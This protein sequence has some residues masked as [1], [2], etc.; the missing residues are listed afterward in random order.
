MKKRTKTLILCISIFIVAAASGFGLWY[1]LRDKAPVG[2]GNVLGVAWYHE[3]GTEF[4][5]TT[6][7]ELFELAELSEHYD[8]KDQ[9][10]KLGADIVVNEGNAAD[11]EKIMPQRRWEPITGFAGTF[12][13]QGHTISGLYGLGHFYGV[14]GTQSVFYTT[15]MFADTKQDCVIKNFKLL[16]SYFSSDLNEGVGSISSYGGG[17]FDSIYTDAIIVS[18]KSNNGGIVGLL[19]KKATITNCWFDGE[20]RVEGNVGRFTGGIVGRVMASNGQYKIE[21]CLNTADISSTVTNRG[22][23]TGGIAGNVQAQARITIEDSLTVGDISVD[24]SSAVG[25]FIGNIESSAAVIVENTYVKS[26]AFTH[27]I[28]NANGTMT[29][30]PVAHNEATLTGYDAYKWSELDFENYWAVVEDGTP[31]LQDFADQVPSLEGI[32]KGYDT[33]WYKP[34]EGEYLI[35]TAE[36]LYGFAILSYS[37]DFAGQAIYLGNDIV[38][39]E[40]DAKDWAENAPETR[41]IP[42]S[43]YGYPFDGMFD[44]QG[45]VISGVYLNTCGDFGL[46]GETGSSSIVT[47]LKLENSYLE[48]FGSTIGSV[49]GRAAGTMQNV[50]SNAIVLGRAGNVGGL[51]G[52]VVKKKGVQMADCWFD[53]TVTNL[54]NK[55]DTK[56]IGGLIGAVRSNCAVTNCLNTGTVDASVFNFNQSK[57]E[58][59]TVVPIVGG[60]IGYVEKEI[61]LTIQ[62][63]LNAGQVLYNEAATAAY[64]SAIGYIDGD[65][66]AYNLYA[67]E[68]SCTNHPLKQS[69]TGQVC[70]IK[71]ADLTGYKAYQWTL[72]DFENHWAINKSGTPILKVFAT[73]VPSLAGV[74]KEVDISWYATDKKTFTLDSREDLF[75]FRLMSYNTDFAEKTVKLGKNITVNTGDAAQWAK[76]APKY[77]WTPI[78]TQKYSFKG[79]FD[80]GMHSINGLYVKT[81]T[82]F[83]G[84]FGVLT[85]GTEVKNLKI[86][87]SY[88][89]SSADFL[90]SIVGAGNADLSNIY[91]NAILVSSANGAAG[92]VGRST[93]DIKI[94]NCW[95]DGSA[96]ITG[97]GMPNRRAGGIVA[98]IYSGKTTLSHCLN[99]GSVSA[100]NYTGTNSE[101]SKAVV[102]LIG[103][104]VGQVSRDAEV[105]MDDSLNT[106]LV[107]CNSAATTGYSAVIGYSDGKVTLTDTFATKESCEYQA[108]GKITGTV[109]TYEEADISG[110]GGYQWMNLNFDKYWAVVVNPTASTPILQSFASNVPSLAGIEKLIDTS[111]YDEQK[112]EYVLYDKSDLNGLAYLS[113]SINFE[114]KTIK[115]GADIVVN[116]DMKNPTYKWDSIGS[117]NV[118]FAGTFDGCMHT[119]SGLYVNTDVE[120][121]GLFARTDKTATVKNLILKDSYF[122]SNAMNIGSIAGI[123]HGTFDTIKSEATVVGHNARVGGLIGIN[124]AKGTSLTNCWFAGTVTNKGNGNGLRGTG[125]LV[126]VSYTGSDLTIMNCLNTGTVDASAYEYNQKTEANPQVVVLAGGL[127]GWVRTDVVLTLGDSLNTGEVKVSSKSED[128][129][130]GY[131]GYGS[132]VGYVDG[133]VKN[134]GNFY[135]TAESSP[136]QMNN[137][138][139]GLVVVKKN[140]IIGLGGYQWDRLNLDFKNIWTLVKQ[141][142]PILQSFADKVIDIAKVAKLIDTSWYDGKAGSTYKLYDMADLYG[143]AEL[144]RKHDFAGMTVKL[145]KDI[146][147]NEGKAANWATVAPEYVWTPIGTRAKPFAGT[148]DGCMHTISGLYLKTD[149]E[150]SGL[151]ART[152]KEATVKNLIL[153]NSY[154]ESSAMNIGSIAGIGAGTF[155]T[156]KSEAIVVGHNARVGGLIGMN[157]SKGTKLNNCWFAG[158]VT[159]KGN[160]EGLRGTAGLVAVSYSN[161]DLTIEN[162][163]NTGT[164]DASAYAYNQKTEANPQVVVLAGGLVGWVRSDANLVL[165]DSVNIGEVKVRTEEPNAATNGF[166]SVIGYVDGETKISGTY[167]TTESSPN[168]KNG[169]KAGITVFNKQDIMG[170]VGYQWERLDLDFKSIWTLVEEDTPTLQVFAEKVIDIAKVEKKLDTSWYDENKTEHLLYD[171]ADLYGFAKLSQKYNFQGMTIKLES[172]IEVNSGEATTWATTAPEYKWTPIGNSDTPFKGTFDAQMHSI[173]GLYIDAGDTR[174]IGL[175]GYTDS[176]TIRNLKLTN[177]YFRNDHMYCASISGYDKNGTYSKI[178]SDAIVYST[179]YTIGGLLGRS[180]NGTKMSECWF[181][182]SVSSARGGG[183]NYVGGLVGDAYAETTTITNCLNTAPVKAS[184]TSIKDDLPYVGGLVGKVSGTVNL[185]SSFNSGKIT[186]GVAGSSN[187]GFG[188]FVGGVT[189]TLNLDAKT[190]SYATSESCGYRGY[191]GTGSEYIIRKNQS[192]LK[193]VAA[194]TTLKD[195]SFDSAIW[196]L[197][198][199]YTPI[200][201]SFESTY[202][203]D[204]WYKPDSNITEY[205][206]YDA[207]DLYGL[208]R[209]SQTNDFKGI[210]IKLGD[211]ITVNDE[212]KENWGTKAPERYWLPIG[213]VNKPFMGTF[214]GYN[215]ETGGVYEVSGLYYKAADTGSVGFFSRAGT[216]AILQNFKL[217]NSYFHL[218]NKAYIGSIVGYAKGTTIHNVHAEA[219]VGEGATGAGLSMTKCSFKGTVTSSRVKELSMGGLIGRIEGKNT[220]ISNC[221]NEGTVESTGTSDAPQNIGGLVGFVLSSAATG[222]KIVNSLNIGAVTS[223]HATPTNMDSIVGV[224]NTATVENLYSTSATD[225]TKAGFNQVSVDDIKGDTAKTTLSGFDFAN[226]WLVRENDTP[227]LNLENMV[228]R[229]SSALQPNNVIQMI[230]RFISKGKKVGLMG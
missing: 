144:S 211:K 113:N 181:D 26:E 135:T 59:P 70:P 69:L 229:T 42:I 72:L 30:G 33:S 55:S 188:C 48:A 209:L 83:S 130:N 108:R 63:C 50:Y 90:G 10:I 153:K 31:I 138:K 228:V 51:I 155:D 183:K 128:S 6:A 7:D 118:A 164:V 114:G 53:G 15:G 46:F 163:L 105:T 100:P 213:N 134:S 166:G 157:S 127:V 88:Y 161:S 56:K 214:D 199:G 221:L 230:S 65:V 41:W 24:Y 78:G 208:S 121:V 217:L 206:L 58:T 22:M 20:M 152:D 110:Y 39:N 9:T 184:N 91:S 29:G 141:D 1:L 195:A 132:V 117:K 119:I 94:T 150:A 177:C 80:G 13:G 197:D 186:Y 149:V 204:T 126:G 12:D 77:S 19:N 67:T 156:I 171:M 79:T 106:G 3:N 62:D 92:L 174:F 168:Q 109:T 154:F 76:N 180:G 145:A 147:I 185:I 140:D 192:L 178:Y 167:T 137:G 45:H 86:M 11:W 223:K 112:T 189:G 23:N 5:I 196:T 125:G 210:T 193:G 49:V 115:L 44:G 57:T 71:T 146:E 212:D 99:T 175:F 93:K 173:S 84:F 34:G 14:R 207:A 159:N 170:L 162:C 81:D 54:G 148:F 224:T 201:K 97:T 182:G 38:L 172:D 2:N 158:T 17:T 28:Y 139:N 151:F 226:T 131:I 102:P 165:K 176:A 220:T 202:V 133:K 96:T 64:G 47:N 190:P 85:E 89:E 103:G 143:F 216:S 82:Q 8:F 32:E 40:G 116:A 16:N 68:E 101:T 66:T 27:V 4:T 200:L 124:S 73:E 104:L 205:V 61:P 160:G 25:S 75:G 21:H 222:T 218:S 35:K 123:G 227:I 107:T 194:A 43:T 95:F 122:E 87:N 74:K 98:C 18:Y 191:T 219:L 52:Q 203:D 60:L 36:Q 129:K 136:K 120:C 142:T 37:T 111:W 215:E 225:T 179:S 198:S 169:S 187:T